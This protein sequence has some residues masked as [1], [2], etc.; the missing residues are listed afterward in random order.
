MRG[1]LKEHWLGMI[2]L[3]ISIAALILNLAGCAKIEKVEEIT[4]EAEIANVAYDAMWLQPIYIDGHFSNFIIHPAKHYVTLRYC[5]T[6]T[7]I[8]NEALYDKCVG[9]IGEKESCT[10]VTTFYSGGTVNKRL[11]CLFE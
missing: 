11:Q 5:E 4:V 7:R 2:A 9:R 1:Y 8:N 6:V 10:L 3:I